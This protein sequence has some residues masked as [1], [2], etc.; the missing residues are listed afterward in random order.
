MSTARLTAGQKCAIVKAYEDGESLKSIAKRF[1]VDKSYPSLL[2]KRR[3]IKSRY[4]TSWM[5]QKS[6]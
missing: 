2:A 5:R 1:G 4:T 3:K 6:K